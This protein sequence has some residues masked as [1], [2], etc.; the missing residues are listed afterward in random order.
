MRSRRSALARELRSGSP[1]KTKGWGQ[2]PSGSDPNLFFT[3]LVAAPAAAGAA[4]AGIQ[5]H[6]DDRD[7]DR[8]ENCPENEPA[9]PAPAAAP[10]LFWVGTHDW[11]LTVRTGTQTSLVGDAARTQQSSCDISLP[12]LWRAAPRDERPHGDRA[13]GRRRA[14]AA[15]AHRVRPR[16]A[17]GGSLPALRRL[18]INRGR[19]RRSTSA[20]IWSPIQLTAHTT[21]TVPTYAQKPSMEK[22]GAIHSA[23]ATMAMLIRR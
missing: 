20:R 5:H 7:G 11:T 15:R 2:T 8:Y 1:L 18:Q 23:S 19:A 21:T 17:R 13:R 3:L 14:E 16:G 22:F 10:M 6:E 4:P 12:V 9:R